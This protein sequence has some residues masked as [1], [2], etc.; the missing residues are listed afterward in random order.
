MRRLRCKCSS[1]ASYLFLKRA[2]RACDYS[3]LCQKGYNRSK[4]RS[5][6]A[7]MGKDLFNQQMKY[8][9]GYYYY[10]CYWLLLTNCLTDCCLARYTS[11]ARKAWQIISSYSYYPSILP[12]LFDYHPTPQGHTIGGAV[13]HHYKYYLCE[14]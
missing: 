11:L 14:L 6:A 10:Y 9:F 7:S 5:S 1:I 3:Q 4:I 13:V 12:A 8:Y 2:C